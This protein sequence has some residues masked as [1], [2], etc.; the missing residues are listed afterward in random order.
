MTELMNTKAVAAYLGINEK[1]VYALAKAKAIPCSR[2][3]GKWVFPKKLIDQWIETST[4]AASQTGDSGAE[5]RFLLVAGSDDPCL[6]ILRDLYGRRTGSCLYTAPS[7]STAGLTAIREG[8]ADV[9]TSHLLDGETGDYNVPFAK[10][11]VPSGAVVA[12][13]FYRELGLIVGTGNP[14][15]L[16]GLRDL[17]RRRARIV[18]RQPGSGTRHYFE[19]ELARLSI[20]PKELRGY[21]H[22][23]ATHLE[24]GL[25]VLAGQADAGIG[26]KAAAQMLGLEFVP[27][28]RERFDVLIPKARFFERGI[29]VFMDI[30][31][32]RDFRGRVAAVG[33]YDV[34][35]SG[36]IIAG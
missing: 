23:V 20:S 4:G 15:R 35:E 10:R 11:M 34:S 3:T 25:E 12:S 2:V 28:A 27:L 21:D 14:K 22:V 18:N 8:A 26:T 24:T 32:S 5:R 33:G 17:V 31:G 16:R 7:G 6:G 36:R 13:L 1:K 30:I 9:A 19:L 29:Q